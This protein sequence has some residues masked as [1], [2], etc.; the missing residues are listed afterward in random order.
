MIFAQESAGS[1]IFTWLVLGGFLLF[2]YF[3]LIRPQRKRARQQQDLVAN[4][5]LGDR[6][7]TIGGIMG[8]VRSVEEDSVVIELEYGSIRIAKRAIASKQAVE[9]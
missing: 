4:L 6:V 7:Q 2:F 1:P 9:G 5:E 8:Q 3:L